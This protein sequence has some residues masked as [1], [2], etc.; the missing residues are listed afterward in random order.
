MESGVRD[1]ETKSESR[2]LQV[3]NQEKEIEDKGSRVRNKTKIKSKDSLVRN[4]QAEIE[5]RGSVVRNKQTE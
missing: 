2:R 4:K 3:R 1:M 5:S